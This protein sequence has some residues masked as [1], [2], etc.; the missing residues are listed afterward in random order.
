MAASLPT[1][2]TAAGYSIGILG[3]ALIGAPLAA[4]LANTVGVSD[5]FLIIA[6]ICAGTAATTACAWSKYENR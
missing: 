4:T 3:G 2:S 6:A 1:G 5:T